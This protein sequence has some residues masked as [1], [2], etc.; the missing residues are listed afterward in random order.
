MEK[1]TLQCNKDSLGKNPFLSSFVDHLKK[2]HEVSI[3]NHDGVYLDIPKNI[4]K[5]YWL[6]WFKQCSIS[7]TGIAENINQA[8]YWLL[9]DGVVIQR[10]KVSGKLVYKELQSPNELTEG[11]VYQRV[12]PNS[13]EYRAHVCNGKLVVLYVKVPKDGSDVQSQYIKTL[14]NGYKYSVKVG[15]VDK[16]W[17]NSV[18]YKL[19]SN[20]TFNMYAIDFIY[21]ADTEKFMVVDVLL[22]PKVG[23][24]TLDKYVKAFIGS[25]AKKLAA[26][27]TTSTTAENFFQSYNTITATYL[28]KVKKGTPPSQVYQDILKQYTEQDLKGTKSKKSIVGTWPVPVPSGKLSATLYLDDLDETTPYQ[29]YQSPEESSNNEF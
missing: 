27:N 12:Y 25:K 23:E 22:R 11:A 18:I 26:S 13:T 20:F 17:L 24:K 14:V 29:A 8:L 28:N 10:N 4:S 2:T 1:L 3:D 5:L 16:S 21:D 6:N 19:A 9:E 15:K 7:C